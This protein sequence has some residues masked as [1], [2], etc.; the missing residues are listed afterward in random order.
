MN[1][2]FVLEIVLPEDEST[3]PVALWRRREELP[4]GEKYDCHTC[5]A[6]TDAVRWS[7]VSILPKVLGLHFN[8]FKGTLK[9]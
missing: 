3:S 9:Q 6:K 8:R 2:I 7:Y 5:A 1:T 4:E